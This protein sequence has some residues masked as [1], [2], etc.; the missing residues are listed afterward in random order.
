MQFSK[1]FANFY[2]QANMSS[3]YFVIQKSIY[4]L[5][6]SRAD[7]QN[8][9]DWKGLQYFRK[10]VGEIWKYFFKLEQEAISEAIKLDYLIEQI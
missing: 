3:S 7:G 8:S 2:F 5:S 6:C 1:F 10:K 4:A 9:A